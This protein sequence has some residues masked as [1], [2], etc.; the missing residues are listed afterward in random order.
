MDQARRFPVSVRHTQW[1][2]PPDYL[3]SDDERLATGRQDAQILTSTQEGGRNLGACFD[4]RLAVVQH[5]Q[6]PARAGESTSVLVTA[7]R[8]GW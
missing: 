2:H 7:P 5:Q 6:D 4:Q 8:A 3:A 1:R